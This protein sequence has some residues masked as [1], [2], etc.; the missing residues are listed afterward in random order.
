MQVFHGEATVI[1]YNI[2]CRNKECYYKEVHKNGQHLTCDASDANRCFFFYYYNPSNELERQKTVNRKG[3]LAKNA[4][5]KSMTFDHNVQR[6]YH[7]WAQ[8]S[9][10]S[11]G[12]ILR[13]W[14]MPFLSN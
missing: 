5:W 6:V 9:V 12:V 8:T 14:Q 10:T 4:V 3:I 13:G 2:S 7:R 11:P 1:L